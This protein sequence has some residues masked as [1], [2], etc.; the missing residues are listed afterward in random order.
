MIAALYDAAA[1]EPLTDRE[2]DPAFAHEA[3]A[4]IVADA[5]ASL[6]DTAPADYAAWHIHPLDREPDDPETPTCLYFGAAGMIWALRVLGSR[7]EL[8]ALAEETL[9]RYVER[10][11]FG[12]D[13][14]S[15][16]E[17]ESGILLVAQLVGAAGADTERLRQR[18][19]ENERNPSWELFRGSPGTMLA[20]R[21]AGFAAERERS[22][23]LLLAEW[24][25][26]GLWT[27]DLFGRVRQI[28]GPAHGLAGN[29]HAL[30]GLIDD[31]DLRRRVEPPLRR[32][33]VGDGGLVNWPPTVGAECSRTQWCHGAPGIVST[34]G[35]LLPDDLLLGGA[36]LTWRAGPLAKGAGLCHGTAG[37][38]YALLT[39][40]AVTGDETWLERARRF[41]MHALE[42]VQNARAE[43]GRGRFSLFT[44]DV[45]AALYARSCL[46][47]DPRFP[48][49]DVW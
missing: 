44:G 24:G 12:E 31:D 26:D 14:P 30:R 34:L 17:G 37:N 18:I 1:H 36:E 13:I 29:V 15:L 46:D 4:G 42:Q 2:W 6:D 47:R 28:I 3:I 10:P 11:D 9:R 5:E 40:Y 39:A 32:H 45:G 27:Q 41:A 48:I 23:A 49:M 16:L 35:D 19:V 38:G 21:E 33:A 20:A 8:A 43:H 7:L 25:E 22:A